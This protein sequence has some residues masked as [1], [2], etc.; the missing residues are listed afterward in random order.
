MKCGQSYW[1]EA[2]DKDTSN[3]VSLFT[4]A[5]SKSTVS[6]SVSDHI[7][8][9]QTTFAQLEHTDEVVNE[10]MYIP[11][12]RPFMMYD[13]DYDATIAA[14]RVMDDEKTS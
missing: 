2:Q 4:E 5:L 10:L 8:E 12:L 14:I 6:E 13:R 9:F 1:Q 7:V 11:I 3:K